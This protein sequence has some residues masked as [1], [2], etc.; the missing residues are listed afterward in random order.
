MFGIIRESFRITNNYISIAT[1]LIL[2][3]LIST[4]YLVFSS[5]GNK[6]GLIFTL[7]LF[8]LM[9]GAFLSGWF[10]MTAQAVRSPENDENSSLISEFP[11]GVGEY[12]LSILAFL[13]NLILISSIIIIAVVLLG[14]K[15]IGN[16]GI[17]YV[18]IVNASGSVEAMKTLLSSLSNEQLAKINA[19]NFLFMLAMFFNYFLVMFY[20]PSIFFK[21]KNPFISLFVSLKDLF[22][23]HFFKNIALYLFIS[24]SY[25]CLS[26]ISALI[27]SNIFIHFILTLVNFYYITF[28]I[29]LI[30]N[31][32]YSNYIKIGATIDK[33]V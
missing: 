14:K 19:W 17:S 16:P 4:L 29:V 3:S 18:Q 23:R 31:Y 12:F 5:G 32:Y 11:A 26:V 27:G 6:L 2:F 25:L 33:T 9:T 7:F 8:F 21:Q 13:F 20:A 22:C 1:P 30:F 15:F 28:I 10:Y 24:I